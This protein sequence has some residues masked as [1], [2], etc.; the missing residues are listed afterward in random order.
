MY[1]AWNQGGDIQLARSL[2]WGGSFEQPMRISD[3]ANEKRQSPWKSFF[4]EYE[5]LEA[6]PVSRPNRKIVGAGRDIPIEDVQQTQVL[7]WLRAAHSEYGDRLPHANPAED[8][9]Q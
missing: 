2:N 1:A 8:Q 3:C 7:D 4:V 9:K 5:T 6:I